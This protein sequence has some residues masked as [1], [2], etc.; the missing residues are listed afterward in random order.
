GVEVGIV[1]AA[2]VGSLLVLALPSHADRAAPATAAA[3]A[4]AADVSRFETLESVQAFDALMATVAEMRTMILTD[5]TSDRE[6]SEGMRFLLR[7]LAMSQD[8]SGDGYPQAPHFARMDTPRRKIGGDNPNAEY[9]N[10]AW[11]GAYDY[12]IT[13]HRGTLDHLSFT[14]L[15]RGENGRSRKLGYVNEREL[16]LAPDGSFTLWLTAK[17]PKEPGVWI[18]TE[19]GDGS[20]LVRQYFGDRAKEKPATYQVEVV[21]RKPFDPL[22]PSTDAEVAH[23]IRLTLSA[24]NG[25]GRL[26]HYVT[27]R[28]GESPNQFRLMNSDDFG[29]DISSV[30]NLYVIGTYEIEENEAL[31]VEVERLDVRYWNFAI[32]NPW[33]E[34]VD[35]AQRKTSRTHDDIKVDPD[36]KVRFVIAHGRTDHPNYLETAGHRRGFM[37][38]RW[39]GERDTKAALPKVTKAPVGKAAELARRA[40]GAR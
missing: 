15:L 30:D 12:R 40:A 28:L 14:V 27:P 36:G 34:S 5:S 37:T 33:H 22:P 21:G 39:V 38:F 1:L 3:A 9:D 19:P 35:Y 23:G 24:M 31:V 18:K 7:T 2:V 26:H 17:K 29:A 4:S 8:V 20:V 32:E 13:G 16:E 25:L 6:A 10:F 11:N